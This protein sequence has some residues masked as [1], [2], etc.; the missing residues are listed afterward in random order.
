MTRGLRTTAVAIATTAATLVALH[1]AAAA[2]PAPDARAAVERA[3]PVLQ[4]SAKT[5]VA[6][7]SCVSCH[8]NILPILTLR[9]ARGRGFTIDQATLAE[10]ERKTFRVLTNPR[11]FDDAVQGTA[12]SDPTPNDSWLLVAARAAGLPPDLTQA[13]TL[14]WA[15]ST[16]IQRN[17][18]GSQSRAWRAGVDR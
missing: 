4:R 10:I 2:D 8:H 3:L 6:N 9:L 18:S 1:P 5:F 15:S 14:F 7:R 12:V 16:T 11:A 17:P 13:K